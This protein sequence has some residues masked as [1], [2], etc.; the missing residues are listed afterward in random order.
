M[1]YEYGI[2]Q[3][4]N[5]VRLVKER[6]VGKDRMCTEPAE[7]AR[8]LQEAYKP[9]ELAEE[10]AYVVALSSCGKVLGIFELAVGTINGALIAPLGVFQRLL[11]LNAPG[12]VFAHNHPSESLKPSKE[13]LAMTNRLKEAGELMQITM[14]DSIILGGK[15]YWSWRKNEEEKKSS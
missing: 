5:G 12:F 6:S 15:R 3:G 10:H 9:W 13:D 8:L 14:L 1:I 2:K 4:A 11:L 7:I